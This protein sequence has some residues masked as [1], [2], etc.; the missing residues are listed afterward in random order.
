MD[1]P[2]IDRCGHDIDEL[3]NKKADGRLSGEDAAALER[4]TAACAACRERAAILDWAVEELSRDQR[5]VPA[6]LPDEVMRRIRTLE[7][8]RPRG[9]PSR[10][11]LVWRW[12]PAAAVLAVAIGVVILYQGRGQSPDGSSPRIPVELQ[13][14]STEARSVAVA[15]DFNGWDAVTMKRGE[16]GVFR[17]QLALPPGRYQYAFLVDG[18]KWVPDPRA[19]TIVDSGYGGADSVLDLTL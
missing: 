11:A 13:L 3:L 9:G 10:Q 19:A 16:D 2:R 15:G 6:G 17:V 4:Q 5:A 1:A 18:R 14:A 12:L 7:P 8:S